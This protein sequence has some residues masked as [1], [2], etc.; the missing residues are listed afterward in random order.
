MI[1][2]LL[3]DDNPG[4]Q[5]LFKDAIE[6]TRIKHQLRIA[7]S[8]LECLELLA[9]RKPDLIFMDVIMPGMTG[10]DFIRT[11]HKDPA[12]KAIPVIFLTGVVDNDKKTEVDNKLNIGGVL[13]P[14]LGKPVDP[15][16]LVQMIAKIKL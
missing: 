15:R 8:S 7:S 13:F 14:A 16:K 5:R 2:I 9:V 6:E 1:D 4:D 10:G 3:V 11:L 12:I